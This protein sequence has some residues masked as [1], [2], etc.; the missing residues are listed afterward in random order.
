MDR[1]PRASTGARRVGRVRPDRRGGGAPRAR[2]GSVTARTSGSRSRAAR[3]PSCC[4]PSWSCGSG[5]R[6]HREPGLPGQRRDAALG[7]RAGRTGFG[8][9]RTTALKSRYSSARGK[10]GTL[11]ARRLRRRAAYWSAVCAAPGEAAVRG[12]GHPASSRA[13]HTR[14]PHRRSRIAA[15]RERDAGGCRT[16][17]WL[18]RLE[19]LGRPGALLNPLSHSGRRARAPGPARRPPFR[20]DLTLGQVCRDAVGELATDQTSTSRRPDAMGGVVRVATRRLT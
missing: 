3:D 16:A 7:S 17:A 13:G 8:S 14:L 2:C 19:G 9:L 18:D 12:R 6:R 11:A 5:A 4:A 15:A 1:R 20:L 10:S